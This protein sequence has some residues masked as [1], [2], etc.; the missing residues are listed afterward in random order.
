MQ[1]GRG[2]NTIL[3]YQIHKFEKRKNRSE[4]S[5]AFNNK[6]DSVSTE[7]H[8]YKIEIIIIT[9]HACHAIVII[10]NDNYN[11]NYSAYRKHNSYLAKLK[12]T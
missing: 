4:I 8:L 12:K 1:Y 10:S 3:A 5:R 6:G 7:M 2:H 11:R 9:N